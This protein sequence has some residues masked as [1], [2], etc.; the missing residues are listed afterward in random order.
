MLLYGVIVSSEL[1]NAM[2]DM[3]ELFLLISFWK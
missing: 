1:A 3:H 2:L